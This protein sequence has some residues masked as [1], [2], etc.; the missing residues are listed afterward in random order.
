MAMARSF[1]FNLQPKLIKTA[2]G[3]EATDRLIWSLTSCLISLHSRLTL[4]GSYFNAELAK[5]SNELSG[6]F[7]PLSLQKAPKQS[8]NI[9]LVKK[10]VYI[11]CAKHVNEAVNTTVTM[12]TDRLKRC[13]VDHSRFGRYGPTPSQHNLHLNQK[14]QSSQSTLF[15]SGSSAAKHVIMF[16]YYLK[17]ALL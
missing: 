13:T 6:C 15:L 16:I 10:H 12:I 17:T 9:N 1:V 5:G 2:G 8:S 7:V 14:N 11:K 4:K 3:P